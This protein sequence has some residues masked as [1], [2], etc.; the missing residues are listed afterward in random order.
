LKILAAVA[1]RP[2]SI[3]IESALAKNTDDEIILCEID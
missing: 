3:P 2:Q 1:N